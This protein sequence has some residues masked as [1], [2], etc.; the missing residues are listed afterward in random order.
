MRR[1]KRATCVPGHK[2]HHANFQ[3]ALCVG[4][5]RLRLLLPVIV[6]AP[7]WPLQAS[8]AIR[9]PPSWLL[10]RRS[11]GDGLAM[12]RPSRQ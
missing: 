11:R 6:A 7:F 1:V 5:A 2:E 10:V 4:Q 3:A 8:S 12:R 9:G